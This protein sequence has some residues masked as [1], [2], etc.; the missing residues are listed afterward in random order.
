MGFLKPMIVLFI[1][2]CWLHIGLLM[3]NWLNFAEC[4]TIGKI[5]FVQRENPI[6]KDYVLYLFFIEIGMAMAI[7]GGFSTP[8]SRV[9][10]KKNFGYSGF[11]L[12]RGFFFGVGEFAFY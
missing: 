2:L 5:L 12:K 8:G 10:M 3:G 11:L 7:F 1:A 9:N 4:P 6:V